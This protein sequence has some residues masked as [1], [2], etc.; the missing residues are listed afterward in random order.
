MVCEVMLW[1]EGINRKLKV[2]EGSAIYE[3]SELWKGRG[4]DDGI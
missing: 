3:V 1:K 2:L 4:D